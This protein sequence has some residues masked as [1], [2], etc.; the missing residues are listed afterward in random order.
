MKNILSMFQE[1]N[2]ENFEFLIEDNHINCYDAVN[3]EEKEEN[4][5]AEMK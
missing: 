4:I 2:L 3:N 1:E 5:I